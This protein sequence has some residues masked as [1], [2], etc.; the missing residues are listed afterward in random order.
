MDLDNLLTP[1]GLLHNMAND[2]WHPIIFR[3]SPRPS[4]TEKDTSI[5]FRSSYHH[6]DGFVTRKIATE[7]IASQ[8]DWKNTSVEWEWDGIESP[9]MTCDFCLQKFRTHQ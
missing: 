6:T 1:A 7:F 9:H 2:R 5:R 4:D 3:P 8:D